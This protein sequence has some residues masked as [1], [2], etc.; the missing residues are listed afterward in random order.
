MVSELAR[1]CRA[2]SRGEKGFIDWENLG[3]AFFHVTPDAIAV[4]DT[5][6]QAVTSNE[7]CRKAF[8]ILPGTI[9]VSRLPELSDKARTVVRTKSPVHDVVIEYNG[10]HFSVGLHPVLRKHELLGIL[11]IFRE[12]TNIDRVTIQ[13][14]H[15]QQLSDELDSLIESSDDGLWICDGNGDVLRLNS[16]SERLAGIN[17]GDVI[18]KNMQE[19]VSEGY[20]NK[21]VTLEVLRTGRKISIFQKTRT[22][23]SLYLTGTPMF[24]SKTGQIL[25]VVVNERDI[26]EITKLQGE[27]EKQEELN[28]QYKR[29]LLEMQIEKT[30]LRQIIA[31]SANYVKTIQT[32]VKLGSVDSTVLILGE[33]GT[34]KSML[35]NLIHKYSA[36]ANE[37]LIK[38]NCGAIPESLVES[39]LFGYEKGAFTGAQKSGK[40]GKFEIADKGTLFLDEIGELPLSSQVKLL[41]FLEDGK[42]CRVGGTVSKKIDV[43]IIA[44][45]NQDLKTMIRNKIF[46]RDLYYR[47]NV[48]PLVIPPLRERRDC[49]LSLLNHYLEKFSLKFKKKRAVTLIP[50]VVDVLLSYAYPGNVRELI[51]ICERLVV[52]SSNG[53]MAYTDLP[54]SVLSTVGDVKSDTELWE[55]GLTLQEMIEELEKT[56]L[57]KTM[58]KYRTQ[59]RTAKVLGLNQSTVARK[60][61]KYAIVI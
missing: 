15:Y 20:I 45:T 8:G 5:T 3:K 14:K 7:L 55:R 47:L 59:D 57:E 48:V 39:E 25:R 16:A 60:L 33:S 54:A 37:P 24:D 40:P 32:A 17:A 36:R 42:V 18:G 46:R 28:D 31:K 50:E 4:F 6:C 13:M 10:R 12:V 27:L 26:T 35:A 9:L 58:E 52:L 34:G 1:P 19:M 30:E 51:N 29:D 22:G 43:R 11:F 53:K 41:G 56:V 49:I 61:K 2:P 38:L 44:A 21:S 23:K